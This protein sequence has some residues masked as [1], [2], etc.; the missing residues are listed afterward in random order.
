MTVSQEKSDDLSCEVLLIKP[1]GPGTGSTFLLSSV[2]I[3]IVFVSQITC[4][5]F[6]MHVAA[7]GISLFLTPNNTV[8]KATH[9][10]L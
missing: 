7:R 10:F 2:Q 9:L 4:K 1:I 6:G 3:A 5:L 8:F